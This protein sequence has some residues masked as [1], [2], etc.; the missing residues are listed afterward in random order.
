M[1]IVWNDKQRF[2]EIWL[3][4]AEQNDPIVQQKLKKLYAEMN[5]KKYTPVVFRSGSQNLYEITSRHLC[6]NRKRQAEKEAATMKI[7]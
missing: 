4:Q 5:A 7:E 1:E 3:S 2:G 6:W